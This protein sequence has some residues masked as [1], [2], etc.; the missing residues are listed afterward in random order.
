MADPARMSQSARSALR[1]WVCDPCKMIGEPDEAERHCS[2]TGHSVREL[3]R[4]E[5]DGIRELWLEERARRVAAIRTLGKWA[6]G[7]EADDA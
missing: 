3:S 5:T 7:E 6:R 4:E 2:L 1:L